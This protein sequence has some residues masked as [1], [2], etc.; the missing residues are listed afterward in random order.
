MNQVIAAGDNWSAV[1]NQINDLVR[2]SDIGCMLFGFTISMLLSKKI[3]VLCAAKLHSEHTIASNTD[4]VLELSGELVEEAER[5]PNMEKLEHFR[6]LTC[7]F[8]GAPISSFVKSL[9]QEISFR[10]N[11]T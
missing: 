6:R 2:D 8:A 9:E 10:V 3:E 7:I 5:L 1:E 4:K 11:A